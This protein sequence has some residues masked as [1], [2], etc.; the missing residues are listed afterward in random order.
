M[1]KWIV[2]SLLLFGL[3]G[4]F[5]CVPLDVRAR[6]ELSITV[7]LDDILKKN[8]VDKNKV[9]PGGKIPKDFKL[10]IPFWY[11]TTYDIRDNQQ[12]KKYKEQIKDLRIVQLSYKLDENSLSVEIPSHG[13]QLQVYLSDVDNKKEEQFKEVGFLYPIPAGKPNIADRLQFLEQGEET[14]RNYF[15][16]LAFEFAVKGK[17]DLDGA[18]NQTVP[19]GKLT[20]RLVLDV[21]FMINLAP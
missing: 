8:G 17:I 7:D 14:A 9:F 6:E 18:I 13:H 15:E 10:S 20:I 1:R 3:W 5:A 19:S 11:A 12:I 4:C 16:K 21:E 2:F